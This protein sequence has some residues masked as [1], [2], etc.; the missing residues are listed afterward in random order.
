MRVPL[1]GG[2]FRLEWAH[3]ITRE[4][5]EGRPRGLRVL[6][7]MWPESRQGA[8]VARFDLTSWRE[9]VIMLCFVDNL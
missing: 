9:S 3:F 8:P 2:R 6:Y 1:V 5:A 4:S 7:M